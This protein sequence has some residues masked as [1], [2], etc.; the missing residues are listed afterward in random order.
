MSLE[1][2]RQYNIKF[3]NLKNE[4]GNEETQ[5]EFLILEIE[6]LEK[7]ENFLKIVINTIFNNILKKVK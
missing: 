5:K 3:N 1:E 6:N 7:Q 4:K 2:R